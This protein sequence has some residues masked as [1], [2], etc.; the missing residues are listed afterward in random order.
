MKLSEPKVRV[1]EA[2]RKGPRYTPLSSVR[3]ARMRFSGWCAT[4]PN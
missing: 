4:I 2:K 3:I 1:P